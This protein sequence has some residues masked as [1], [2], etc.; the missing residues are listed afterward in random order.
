MCRK[1]VLLILFLFVF[2]V[3]AVNQYDGYGQRA[4]TYKVDIHKIPDPRLSE[5]KK[6]YVMDN[7]FGFDV[8]EAAPNWVTESFFS[9]LKPGNLILDS[10]SGYGALTRKALKQNA[11]VISNDISQN[12]LLYN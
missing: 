9:N 7:Q 4:D 12:A 1:I 2:D 6:S 11:I 10:G 5:S 3:Q 8:L